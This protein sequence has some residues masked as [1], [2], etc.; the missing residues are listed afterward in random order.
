[1][2]VSVRLGTNVVGIKVLG[3][4]VVGRKVVGVKV[5]GKN[6]VGRNVETEKMLM[7]TNAIMIKA[8]VTVVG[9]NVVGVKVVGVNVVGRKV[10][11]PNVVGKNMENMKKLKAVSMA[12]MMLLVRDVDV[13][14]P[15]IMIVRIMAM[16]ATIIIAATM[17][18]R[19]IITVDVGGQT[20]LAVVSKGMPSIRPTV[21]VGTVRRA[22]RG[23]TS[24][25]PG[26]VPNTPT[27]P[28]TMPNSQMVR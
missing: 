8:G 7:P 11:G 27:T 25:P 9:K 20:I 6:V 4:N 12:T 23:A 10:V 2:T 28:A 3:V 5:V 21:R 17:V 1:M 26:T 13:E 18:V 14:I 19:I 22:A 16:M 15:D 24:R